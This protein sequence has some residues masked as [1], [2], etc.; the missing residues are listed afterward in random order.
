MEL[1]HLLYRLYIAPFI[2]IND[3]ETTSDGST[4][5]IAVENTGFLRSSVMTAR[6]DGQDPFTQRYYDH[7]LVTV[8]ITDPSGFTVDG[9]NSVNIGWLGGGRADDPEPRVK[10]A[11]F[12]V[13]GLSSGDTFTVSAASD[14]TGQVSADMEVVAGKNGGLKLQVVSTNSVRPPDQARAYFLGLGPDYV[15]R[16]RALSRSV[17]QIRAD[18]DRAE[19]KRQQWQRIEGPF[20]VIPG[21]VKGITVR[22]YH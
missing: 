3:E 10:V 22:K 21:Y 1:K 9:P 18:M 12:A 4:L 6:R 14:K 7:G 17:S 15:R 11:G 8:L 19:K 20:D 16:S 13:S 5:D 2:R